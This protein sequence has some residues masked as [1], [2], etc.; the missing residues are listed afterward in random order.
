M[1][2]NYIVTTMG[3]TWVRHEGEPKFKNTKTRKLL[4]SHI[5]KL[6]FICRR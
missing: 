3:L 4:N 2:T 5:K 6:S 1:E